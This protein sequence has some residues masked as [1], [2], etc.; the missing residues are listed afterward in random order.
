MRCPQCGYNK[1]D[2]LNTCSKC[3]ANLSEER[4]RLNLPE[5]PLDPI[6]LTEILKL[7]QSGP[8]KE[9]QAVGGTTKIQ[10]AKPAEPKTMALDL[11]SDILMEALAEKRH[12]LP[13]DRI[14]M[15]SEGFSVDLT[16]E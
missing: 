2:N 6:S 3:R 5:G 7:V 16:L 10:P 13:E 9:V 11:G 1:F 4:N 12:P 15:P 14:K 8:I